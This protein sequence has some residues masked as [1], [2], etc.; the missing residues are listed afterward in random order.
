MSRVFFASHMMDVT[1]SAF[2]LNSDL[3]QVLLVDVTTMAQIP[4][5]SNFQLLYCTT[6]F[7]QLN[8]QIL[9]APK[10]TAST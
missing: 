6:S 7:H 8:R 2:Q 4:S 3:F 9:S 1:D 5:A 10:P